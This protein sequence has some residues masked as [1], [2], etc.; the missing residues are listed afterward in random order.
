MRWVADME[1]R[2]IRRAATDLVSVADALEWAGAVHAQ[3]FSNAHD[4]QVVIEQTARNKWSA[5][6]SGTCVISE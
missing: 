2:F 4:L 3:E 5:M 6:I 1:E